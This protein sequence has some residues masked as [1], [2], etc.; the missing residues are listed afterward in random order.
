MPKPRSIAVAAALA[1]A[2]SLPVAPAAHAGHSCS[3]D[4]HPTLDQICESHGIDHPIIRKLF[5]LVSPTC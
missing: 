5:C 4:E 3:L 2:A 1:A